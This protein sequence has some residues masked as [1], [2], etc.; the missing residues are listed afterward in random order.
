MGPD[1]SSLST[2][3]ADIGH[4]VTVDLSHLLEMK[5]GVFW[6]IL[7]IVFAAVGVW[8]VACF[9]ILTKLDLRYH[10]WTLCVYLG[11][12]SEFILPIIGDQ[13]FLP[14][15]SILLDIFVC[16]RAYV[17]SGDPEMTDSFLSRDCHASCWTG[18]HRWYVGFAVISL[19]SYVPL[20]V[21]SRPLWQ[22]YKTDLHIKTL[23]LLLMI[24][25]IVQML[26]IILNKT[27]FRSDKL[28]HAILFLAFHVAYTA[29][30]AKLVGF[31]YARVWF[32]HLLSLMGVFWIAL[33]ATMD[34][35]TDANLAWVCLLFTGWAVL[36]VFGVIYQ[37]K[38]YP[39]L[40]Y[41]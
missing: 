17:E 13:G 25:T 24:K 39:K 18:E 31:S 3:L 34:I 10:G 33:M 28:T 23:P 14:I 32:W 27:T 16:D 41:R 6:I 38:R 11:L 20:A 2:F 36:V 21:Y 4:G 19:I 37:R 7:D 5:E 26:Y 15:V 9:I 1:F 12:I 30:N 35:V 22:D 40:L 8:I 29:T